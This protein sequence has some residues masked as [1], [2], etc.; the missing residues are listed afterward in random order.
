MRPPNMQ[1]PVVKCGRGFAIK[2]LAVPD[3]DIYNS[4]QTIDK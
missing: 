1:P 4:E 3:V 2:A